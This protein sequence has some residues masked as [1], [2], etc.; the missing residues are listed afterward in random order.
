MFKIYAFF[1]M[2]ENHKIVLLPFCSTTNYK[3]LFL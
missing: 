2:G 1:D 3:S